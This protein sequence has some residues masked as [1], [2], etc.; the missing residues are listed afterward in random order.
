MP[1]PR[2][3][4]PTTPVA[5]LDRAAFLAAGG[6]FTIEEVAPVVGMSPA[7][8]KKVVGKK[9][10]LTADD[11]VAL[12]DQD[13]Y[14]ETFIPRSKVPAYLTANATAAAAPGGL[15]EG[16][17]WDLQQGHVLDRVRGLTAASVDCVVTSPPY[18][19]MRVYQ[20]EFEATWADGEVCPFGH[21]QTPEGYLRHTTEILAALYD[22]LAPGGS[23]WWNVMDTYNTRTQ[24]RGNAAEALRA[25]QGKDDKGWGDHSCRR[26]SAGHAFLLDGEQCMIPAR[27]AE[28]ASRLG[29][30]VKST[31]TWAKTHSL[32]EPQGSRV[33]RNLEYVLHLTKERSPK[34]DKAPYRTLTKELGGR[35]PDHEANKLSDVWILPTSA[36]RDGH[37][38]QFPLALPGR[39]IAIS[40]D[41]GDVVLD[42]FVGSGNSGVAAL[43]LER[44]FIGF[45]VANEYLATA[46]R[47][48]EALNS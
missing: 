42:P 6:L 34:F 37:G 1:E 17:V 21:E 9:S 28:R 46:R 31:I 15:S 41:P 32:P 4:K 19:G 7:F 11:V 16:Q 35:N 25:M 23:V 12:L 44:R 8:I 48:L 36:G 2:D 20:E 33:S 22:A 10:K 39:C 3:I 13:A 45:D 38:A 18:W 40:T 5:S 47:K 24:V 43:R 26:Y 30:Y 29:F 14:Q 27:I